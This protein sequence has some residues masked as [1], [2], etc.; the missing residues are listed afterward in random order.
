L[1]GKVSSPGRAWKNGA[2]R[3][4]FGARVRTCALAVFFGHFHVPFDFD[5]SKPFFF[6]VLDVMLAGLIGVGWSGFLMKLD[7]IDWNKVYE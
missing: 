2:K 4:T 6:K 7:N 5:L 3:I 1:K